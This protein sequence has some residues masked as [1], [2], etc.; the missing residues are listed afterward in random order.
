MGQL[1][2]VQN[3]A[4]STVLSEFSTSKLN[5]KIR[6]NLP[7]KT[8]KETAVQRAKIKEQ[9][10]LVKDR[11]ES[12]GITVKSSKTEIPKLD[13]DSIK[14][15]NRDKNFPK[16]TIETPSINLRKDT[17]KLSLYSIEEKTLQKKLSIGPDPQNNTRHVSFSPPPQRTFAEKR[18][19]ETQ[20]VKRETSNS[21]KKILNSGKTIFSLEKLH[22]S[23][24][25]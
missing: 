22:L 3:P 25:T 6:K 12:Q 19:K 11:L 18:I 2:G 24:I 16:I 14:N 13:I 20:K 23:K 7:C 9:Q 15:L 10:K 17:K 1:K 8:E 4:K 21:E 5:L